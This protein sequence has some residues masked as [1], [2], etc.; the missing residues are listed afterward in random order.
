M[1]T[2]SLNELRGRA[3]KEPELWHEA[4]RV[5]RLM[6]DGISV[7]VPDEFPVVAAAPDIIPTIFNAAS[8]LGRVASAIVRGHAVLASSAVAAARKAVCDGCEHLVSA[9][10][11]CNICGCCTDGLII[12]KTKLATEKC[13]AGKWS[14]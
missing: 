2:I 12:N 1:K 5:G 10:G 14:E 8:A 9:T 13:P 6:P 7:E 4:F 3:L 11:R